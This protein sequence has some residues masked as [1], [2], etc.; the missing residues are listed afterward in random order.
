MI[1]TLFAAAAPAHAR[2]APGA[3]LDALYAV[4]SG[5]AGEA[6]DWDRSGPC[7]LQARA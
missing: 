6:R 3:A 2:E 4:L 1:R 7:S 5:P